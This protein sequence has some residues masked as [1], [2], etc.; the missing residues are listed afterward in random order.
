MRPA[1]LPLTCLNCPSDYQLFSRPVRAFPIA[2][3]AFSAAIVSSIQFTGN[4]FQ[5]T[6]SYVYMKIVFNFQFMRVLSTCALVRVDLG[7]ILIHIK[8]LENRFNLYI[9]VVL[10]SAKLSKLI[11]VISRRIRSSLSHKWMSSS[12]VMSWRF[13]YKYFYKAFAM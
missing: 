11:S 2:D 12:H 5:H 10:I 3:D 9:V 6:H 7:K 1:S 13:I 4:L 8:R